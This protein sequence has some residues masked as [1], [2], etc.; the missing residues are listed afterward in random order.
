[1]K[2]FL[3]LLTNWKY[4]WPVWLYLSVMVLAIIDKNL[5]FTPMTLPISAIIVIASLLLES[6]KWQGSIVGSL[7]G[8]YMIIEYYYKLHINEKVLIDTRPIGLVIIVCYIY[9]GYSCFKEN[10]KE[11]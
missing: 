7:N 5:Y 4:T 2:K 10:R 9:M 8:I 3:K 1:M 11:K 6:S